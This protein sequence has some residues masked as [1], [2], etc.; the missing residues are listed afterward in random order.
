M[1]AATA[2]FHHMHCASELSLIETNL[3]DAFVIMCDVE[4]ES[5]LIKKMQQIFF[6]RI[7]RMNGS[8]FMLIVR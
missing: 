2:H 1:Y 5:S 6:L 8:E 7:F 4:D 3:C